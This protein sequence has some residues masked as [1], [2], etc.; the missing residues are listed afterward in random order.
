MVSDGVHNVSTTDNDVY[1]MAWMYGHDI[2]TGYKTG[3]GFVGGYGIGI[4]VSFDSGQIQNNINH[5]GILLIC[6]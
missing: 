4:N 3:Y 5:K 6:S 2:G 1:F